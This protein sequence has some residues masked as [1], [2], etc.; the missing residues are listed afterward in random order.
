MK[1][2]YASKENIRAKGREWLTELREFGT[3]R[4]DFPI[5]ASKSALLIID[6]QNFFLSENLHGF[7][8]SSKAVLHNVEMLL[9]AFRDGKH[10]VVF[11]RHALE[12]G[13]DPGI[14]GRWWADVI[15]EGASDSNIV[16]LLEPLDSEH[17]LRKTRYSAFR[18]TTLEELL[19]DRG[20]KSLVIT[21]VMTHLCCE[22]TARDAFIRDFEVFFVVDATATNYEELHLSSLR[23]L[24]DGF[25]IPVTTDEVLDG[26]G[27]KND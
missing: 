2:S 23:T 14:M 13:E 5:D 20:V 10:L 7:I 16:S 27:G 18:G 1:D 11:T 12:E 26:M 25:A 24:S 17:V 4:E 21:G 19:K 22:S 3:R 15:R 8:P 9:K 6:M